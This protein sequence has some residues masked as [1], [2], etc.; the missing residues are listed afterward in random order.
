[1]QGIILKIEHRTDSSVWVHAYTREHG[2]QVYKVFGAGGKKKRLADLSPM[3][4]AELT[5]TPARVGRETVSEVQLLYV[6]QRIPFEVPR[7]VLALYMSEALC[8]VLTHVM[9]D[10]PLYDFLVETIKEL[11]ST[12]EWKTLPQTFTRRLSELLG[13]GGASIPELKDLKSGEL[14]TML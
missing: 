9:A 2:R 7:Q 1:M 5:I 8:R 11:D 6:P 12:E 10:E 13:Y 4:W 14:L 3:S